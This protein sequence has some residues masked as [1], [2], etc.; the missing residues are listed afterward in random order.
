MPFSMLKR[1][2]WRYQLRRGGLPCEF[3]TFDYKPLPV[4]SGFGGKPWPS[5]GDS[6]HDA[7]ESKLEKP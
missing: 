1:G 4:I 7:S 5:R 6:S 2:Q 3:K